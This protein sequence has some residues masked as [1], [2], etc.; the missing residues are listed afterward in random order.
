M[1]P[2]RFLSYV[3]GEITCTPTK[4]KNCFCFLPRPKWLLILRRTPPLIRRCPPPSFFES[5]RR[6]PAFLFAQWKFFPHDPTRSF[7]H[8]PLRCSSRTPFPLDARPALFVPT[9]SVFSSVSDPTRILAR[10]GTHPTPHASVECWTD[11]TLG[12]RKR[13]M[14]EIWVLPPGRF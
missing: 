12:K 14:P 6:S 8:A 2:S 13:E 9:L 1:P 11:Q 7:P 3:V 5:C 10:E 4:Y